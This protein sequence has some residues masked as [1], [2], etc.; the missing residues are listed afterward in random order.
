M[1]AGEDISMAA[2]DLIHLQNK[3]SVSNDP[4]DLLKVNGAISMQVINLEPPLTSGY[5]KI[6]V[7]A[8]DDKLYFLDSNGQLYDLTAVTSQRVSFSV[9]RDAS[10]AWPTSSSFENVD[11]STSTTILDNTGFGFNNKS[12][13]F[14]A[15]ADGIY[16]FHGAICFTSLA[17]GDEISAAINAAGIRYRADM[18]SA[19]GGEETVRASITLYLN[20]DDQ[21]TLEG[22]ASPATPPVYSFGN[23]GSTEVFTFFAGARVD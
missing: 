6:F 16:T 13:I 20:E 14:I 10:Y 11:F 9:K 22:Y 15:P 2:D 21:V 17:K 8:T 1:H 19:S 5:G 18:T 23:P 12:G 3:V 4:N 7:S